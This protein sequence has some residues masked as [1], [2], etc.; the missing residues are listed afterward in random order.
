MPPG[1]YTL[2]ARAIDSRDEMIEVSVPVTVQVGANLGFLVV[3]LVAG[4]TVA[5]VFA[6]AIARRRRTMRRSSSST[7][8]TRQ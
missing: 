5:I 2:F 4:V 7:A 1:E 6:V 3:L 8:T